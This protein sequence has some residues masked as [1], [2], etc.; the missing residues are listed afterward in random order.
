MGWPQ[1]LCV[2]WGCVSVGSCVLCRR[3]LL[4]R[5]GVHRGLYIPTGWPSDVSPPYDFPA[6]RH[7]CDF[8]YRMRNG[9]SWV[10]LCSHLE[11]ELHVSCKQPP[12]HPD[13]HTSL[14]T[15]LA[16][17]RTHRKQDALTPRELS[18]QKKDTG[19]KALDSRQLCSG[20]GIVS[21]ALWWPAAISF[22]IVLVLGAFRF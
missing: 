1:G 18:A 3:L 12:P 9:V 8:I 15:H 2:C 6:R 4:L 5:F 21:R 20:I 17:S 14:H 7:M 10:F 16:P 19:K 11:K 22:A 13:A